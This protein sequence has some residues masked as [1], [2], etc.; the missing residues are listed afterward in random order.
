M[1]I[2]RMV[3]RYNL[4]STSKLLRLSPDSVGQQSLLS[5]F[6]A[7]SARVAL[8]TRILIAFVLATSSVG[9]S[10]INLDPVTA[11]EFDVT[12]ISDPDRTVTFL[13]PMVWSNVPKYRA[14]KGVRLLDGTYVLEAE[15]ESFLYFRSPN[16]IE[17]RVLRN[18]VPVDGRDFQGGLALS[19]TFIT[20]APASA[21]V[22]INERRK[23]HVMKMGVDFLKLEDQVWKK[24]F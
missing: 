4:G 16:P 11:E 14:T 19:K 12:P 20:L 5:R 24:S 18:G 8:L 23:M 10:L 7:E 15:S 17:M 1:T 3:D 13:E 2:R 21:Y 9:C 6:F 22:S